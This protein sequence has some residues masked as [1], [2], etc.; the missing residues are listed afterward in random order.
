MPSMHTIFMGM[1]EIFKDVKYL[2]IKRFAGLLGENLDVTFAG[3][4]ISPQLAASI[5]ILK[6]LFLAIQMFA[7]S[8]ATSTYTAFAFNFN[9]E[10]KDQTKL[11]LKDTFYITDC[12][13]GFGL[14]AVL[15]TLNPILYLWIGYPLELSYFFCILKIL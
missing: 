11:L 1:S 7:G 8:I 9:R 14:V 5:S 2:Y 13:Q 6:K 3:M 12:I 4:F 15:V 10:N